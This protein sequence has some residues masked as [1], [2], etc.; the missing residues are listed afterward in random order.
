MQIQINISNTV[1]FNKL[2]EA[3]AHKKRA[4]FDLELI[5][6]EWFEPVDDIVPSDFYFR[7]IGASQLD[8][9]HVLSTRTMKADSWCSDNI[10]TAAEFLNGYNKSVHRNTV[11][12]IAVFK[13]Q[14]IE[15]K[16]PHINIPH[17]KTAHD[18]KLSGLLKIKVV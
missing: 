11:G 18:V 7:A 15:I 4:N 3:G 10:F 17:F 9:E 1:L 12:T 6:S 8:S 2:K 5:S 14:V 13:G 16:R